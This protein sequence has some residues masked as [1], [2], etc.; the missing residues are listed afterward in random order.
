MFI[1][2]LIGQTSRVAREEATRRS[3]NMKKGLRHLVGGLPEADNAVSAL[4]ISPVPGCSRNLTN[5]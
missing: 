2:E 4:P 3:I 5:Q 1:N